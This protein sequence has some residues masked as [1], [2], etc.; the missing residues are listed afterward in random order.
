M[1]SVIIPTLNSEVALVHTLAALVPAAAEGVVRE[2]VLV[3]GGSSDQTHIVADAAGCE[4][5]VERG[6]KSTR[7]AVG[8]AKA[9][10]GE[11]LLFLS[12]DTVLEP[13]WFHEAQAFMERTER[14][15][16]AG[17]TAAA[18]KLKFEAF[19]AGARLA[20]F[21]ASVRSQVLGVPYGNQGLLL[22]RRFYDQLG[23][24]RPL[25]EMEDIDLV[26]RIGRRRLVCLRAA[27]ISSGR[28]EEPGFFTS[29][30]RTI[31]RF[32]VGTLRLPTKLVLKLHG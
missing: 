14:A 5:C 20:E 19:G 31:A 15:G 11:W 2:V 4:W 16:T 9:R 1:I 21:M 17:R 24:Y 12:P 7:L 18:F 32:C 30:R 8:A 13:G 28:L 27:A 29:L 10:R 26:K 3:D 23:G 6:P 22:S 25:P